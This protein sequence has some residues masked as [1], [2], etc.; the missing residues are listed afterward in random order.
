MDTNHL[1]GLEV[2]NEIFPDC[3]VLL[4][5]LASLSRRAVDFYFYIVTLSVFSPYCFLV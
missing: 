3:C 2:A 1:S 5:L 4:N